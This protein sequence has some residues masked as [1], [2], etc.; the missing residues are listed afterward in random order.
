MKVGRSVGDS[1][2]FKTVMGTG[3]KGCK[4]GRSTVARAVVSAVWIACASE[5]VGNADME[6]KNEGGRTA[7][8]GWGCSSD[9]ELD[10]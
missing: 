2:G 4:E 8:I 7:A 1:D 9:E 10:C 3:V 5:S 6:S